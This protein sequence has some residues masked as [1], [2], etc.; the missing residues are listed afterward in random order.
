MC[1]YGLYFPFSEFCSRWAL[2]GCGGI[3]AVGLEPPSGQGCSTASPSLKNSSSAYAHCAHVLLKVPPA[4]C[5]AQLCSVVGP[6]ETA[7]TVWNQLETP[8]VGRRQPYPLSTE[9]LRIP[10]HGCTICHAIPVCC[11][12]VISKLSPKRKYIVSFNDFKFQ[13]KAC[14]PIL[15]PGYVLLSV[16]S[17]YLSASLSLGHLCIQTSHQ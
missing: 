8:V 17:S 13:Q 9:S 2:Q 10:E 12:D 15:I 14:D 6:L 3:P 11:A 5:W 4:Q 16:G 7:G 1:K